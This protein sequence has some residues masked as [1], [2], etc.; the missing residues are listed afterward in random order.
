[1]VAAPKKKSSRKKKDKLGHDPLAWINDED[2]EKLKS[3]AE[4]DNVSDKKEIEAIESDGIKPMLEEIQEDKIMGKQTVFELPPYFGI[5]Q[6]AATKESMQSFLENSTDEIEIEAGDVESIDTAALQLLASFI[7]EAKSKDK[8]IK[9]RLISNKLEDSVKLLAM[10][11][12][13]GIA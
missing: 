12:E 6:V 10:K 9:W 2:V 4:E 1:M 8:C 11:E 7:K 3:E 5:A 13:L